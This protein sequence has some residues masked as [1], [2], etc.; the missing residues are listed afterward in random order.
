ME[1]VNGISLSGQ[2]DNEVLS[3]S[4]KA[5]KIVEFRSQDV[6]PVWPKTK[7]ESLAAMLFWNPH[8]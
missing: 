2:D 6:L 3:E 8:F 1:D 4:W 7:D 5:H